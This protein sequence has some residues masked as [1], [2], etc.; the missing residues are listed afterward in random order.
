M[1]VVT[2]RYTIYPQSRKQRDTEMTPFDHRVEMDKVFYKMEAAKQKALACKEKG[3][4]KTA[5][6]LLSEVPALV[7]QYR[8]HQS[9]IKRLLK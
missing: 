1:T 3:Q 8:F 9:E 6:K 2:L 4:H 7:E 5:C